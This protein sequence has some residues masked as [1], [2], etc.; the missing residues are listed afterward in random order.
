MITF[1]DGHSVMGCQREQYDVKIILMEMYVR[2]TGVFQEISFLSFFFFLLSRCHLSLVLPTLLFFLPS[3]TSHDWRLRCDA[4]N[5]YYTLFGL[6]RPSCLPL[7]ELGLVLNLKE[8]KAV[9]NP[10]IKPE[11]G[12]GAVMDTAASIGIHGVGMT[13]AA[14][15]VVGL[16]VSTAPCKCKMQT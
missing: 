11:L 8:K 15:S 3:G 14:V 2:S 7:P 1:L 16:L 12:V 10:T 5:L 4:V 6:T 9:L 13:Y